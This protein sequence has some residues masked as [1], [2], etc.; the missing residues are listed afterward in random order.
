MD[1]IKVRELYKNYGKLEVLKNI[2]LDIK[3]GSIFGLVGHSG[4]GK[5]TL[6]RTFN[7]LESINHG[8][9]KI[10]EV[11]INH[12][13]SKKLRHFR[14]KVGMIFQNF[15]LMTRKNVYENIILPLE[16]WGEHINKNRV[17]KLVELV[18]LQDKMKFYPS[19][20]SGGQKQRVAIARALVM[21]PD[22][23]LSDEATSALDPSTTNSILELLS[24][25]NQEI[26]VTIV[27]VTHEM[28]VV[29]KICQEA[30][31]ME[32]GEIIK[33]G[34]IESLFLE[35]DKKM[36]E[37]LGENE[38]LPQ[39]GINIRIYFPKEV[40]Q[41][42]I[43]TQMARELQVDFNIVWGNLESFG[44]IALGVLVINIKQE[45]LEQVCAFLTQSGTRWEIVE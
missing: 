9:I 24:Q 21:N 1:F 26:K 22:L 8:S 35:P 27:L 23:L 29:K 5:S 7:G 42:P 19:Q 45:F 43:I 17:E 37:F 38:I 31:F 40:A 3:K 12:L 18:G 41:N 44:G 2:H 32:N 6:L 20:L 30:A 25:I 28:E 33:S 14:K 11:E 4:A 13:D 36:R 10:G 16:C 34:P 15:S 39:N